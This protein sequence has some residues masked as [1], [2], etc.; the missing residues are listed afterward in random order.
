ME[1]AD[2]CLVLLDS[3][4]LVNKGSPLTVASIEDAIH[5]HIKDLLQNTHS[6]KETDSKPNNDINDIDNSIVVLNKC[7]LL[8]ADQRD[9]LND[10]CDSIN[11]NQS[12]SVCCMTS[13][14]TDNGITRF[15]DVLAAKVKKM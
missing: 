13:C 8:S 4:T 6:T 1:F 10:V 3:T 12:D 15:V 9:L 5:S 14:T 7:D 2:L 11:E